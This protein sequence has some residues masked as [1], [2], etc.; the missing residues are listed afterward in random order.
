MHAL[1]IGHVVG[2]HSVH[3]GENGETLTLSHSATARSTF[4]DGAI[5]AAKW[6]AKQPAGQYTMAEML[7][8][9]P[10]E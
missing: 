4:S 5:R 9:V 7:G 2:E 3:F 8:L 1:R 6:L 10:I